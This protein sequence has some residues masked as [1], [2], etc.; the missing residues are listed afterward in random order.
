MKLTPCSAA[1]STMRRASA[2]PVGPP[3]IMVPRQSSDTRIPLEPSTRW[4]MSATGSLLFAPGSGRMPQDEAVDAA[5]L[6]LLDEGVAGGL[7]E[8]GEVG[9]GAGVGG[10]HLKRRSLGQLGECLPGLQDRQR[11]GEP[12]QIQGLVGHR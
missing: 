4:R 3:N 9:H 6:A 11:T 12:L 7:A 2:S 8:G 1:W 10:E 5:G